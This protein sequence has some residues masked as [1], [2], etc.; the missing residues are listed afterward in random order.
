MFSNSP[1]NAR[2]LAM[3]LHFTGVKYG[4]GGL[5]VDDSKSSAGYLFD[6]YIGELQ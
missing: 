2:V 1:E 3:F 6:G 4:C 5:F